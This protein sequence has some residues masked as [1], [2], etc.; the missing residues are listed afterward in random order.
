MINWTQR[1]GLSLLK[2][3]KPIEA[4]WVAI[5][6]HSIDI[7][8]KKVLVVL[9]VPLRVIEDKGNAPQL[10][11]C[12]CIGLKISE[13][14]NYEI[15]AEH[16]TEIFDSAG[17]PEVIVKGQA[18]NLSKGVGYWR[19]ARNHRCSGFFDQLRAPHPRAL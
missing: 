6:D 5:L 3:V 8:V 12:E 18:G 1:I 14:T 10:S 17:V 4:P 15:V 11:D 13:R 9:R 19:K 2:R 7:G 16:L